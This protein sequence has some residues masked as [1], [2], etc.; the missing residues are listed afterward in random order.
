[1]KAILLAVL[2]IACVWGSAYGEQVGQVQTLEGHWE[3]GDEYF[4]NDVFLMIGQKKEIINALE[5]ALEYLKPSEYMD[6]T[7]SEYVSPANQLRRQADYMEQRDRD[8]EFIRQTLS[9]L[10][11]G[12]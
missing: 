7:T 6:I 1:M 2:F 10:K 8:I 5:T 9:K 11:G 4:G 12:E 3:Y